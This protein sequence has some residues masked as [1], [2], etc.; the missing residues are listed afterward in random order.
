[1]D[2]RLSKLTPEERSALRKRLDEL[3]EMDEDESDNLNVEA[4]KTEEETSSEE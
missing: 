3:D 1:M 2:K 4:D